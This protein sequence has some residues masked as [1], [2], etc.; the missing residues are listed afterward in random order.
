[1]FIN[2]DTKQYPV[3][4]I[5]IRKANPNTSFSTPFKAPNPYQPV[6]ETPEP[7]YNPETHRVE[8]STPEKVGDRWQTAWNV[9]ALT[10]QEKNL[11]EQIKSE[12]ASQNV[13]SE[14]DSLLKDSDWT[15]LADAPISAEKKQEFSQYRQLLRD[16]P[17]QEEFP[18]AVQWPIRPV[19]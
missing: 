3:S 14:R 13:R 10:E 12:T 16:I 18:F 11:K 19:F 8:Q 6:Y 15:Q 9:I 17:N 1:M 5:D 7:V 2:T 4:E